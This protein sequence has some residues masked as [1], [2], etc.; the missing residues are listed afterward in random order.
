MKSHFVKFV[1]WILIPLVYIVVTQSLTLAAESLPAPTISVSPD[2]YYPLDEIIYLEGRAKPNIIVQINF[3]KQG[4]KPLNFNVKA[5]A[6]GEWV[7]AE[8]APLK[9]GNYEVRVRTVQGD[10]TSDW[11]NPRIIKVIVSGVTIGGVNVK[12]ALLTFLLFVLLAL[13]AAVFLY[14]NWR[15]RRLKAVIADKEIQEVEETAREGIAELRKDLL[16]ELKLIES[17]ER[18]LSAEELTRKEHILRELDM[19]E[20]NISREIKDI[21]KI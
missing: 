18:K 16:D 19:L 9:D 6:S 8:K 15:V 20:R 5:D 17:S 13:G 3:Q 10:Q 4:V 12:F 14:F 21:E 11:S 2:V 7:L 1:I